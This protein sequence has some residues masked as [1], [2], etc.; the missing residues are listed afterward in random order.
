MPAK[1]I[2]RTQYREME[3]K[4]TPAIKVLSNYMHN[5]SNVPPDFLGYKIPAG[6]FTDKNGIV[7]QIQAHAICSKKHH[8]KKNE[9]VPMVRKW[10]IGLKIRIF[11]KY[12]V[13]WANK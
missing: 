7:W 4:F 11:I 9:I 13:E 1:S 10:A 6:T 8:I 5:T 2:K 3:S 12:L